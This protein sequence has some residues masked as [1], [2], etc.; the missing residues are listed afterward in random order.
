MHSPRVLLTSLVWFL[1]VGV[2]A[3]GDNPSKAPPSITLTPS[4]ITVKAGESVEVTASYLDSDGVST[5]ASD[6]TFTI[7]GT[8]IA[9]VTTGSGGHATVKGLA[10]GK[11]VLSV[12]GQDVTATFNV[13]VT[14]APVAT[15]SSIE[16]TP[17]NGMIALGTTQQMTATGVYSDASTKDL[18]AEAT[19]SSSAV[20]H[21]TIDA[22][23]IAH[24]VGVGATTITATV[25]TVSGSAQLTVTEAVLA[26]ITVAPADAE[27][28]AGHTQQYTATGHFSDATTQDLTAQ[29]TW[30]S[31]A[32][33]ATISNAAGSQG[34]ASGVS[35]GAATI[36]ATKGTVVG[37]TTLTVTAATLAAIEVT[38]PDTSNPIG[39]RRPLK[40]E[41]TFSDTST[42]TITAD[43]TWSSSDETIATVALTGPN[44]GEVT[45]VAKGTATI[46]AT[47]DGITGNT[48]FIVTDATLDTIEVTPANSST[49]LG[50][51]VQFKAE[52]K[53][54]DDSKVDLTTQVL[55]GSTN[56]TIAT[57]SNA[58]DKGNA[59]TLAV[60]T[61]TITAVF[62]SKSGT[63]DLTVTPVALDAVAVTPETAD[64][65]PGGKKQLA[66][67]EVFSDATSVDVSATAVWASSDTAIATVD[68]KGLVTGAAVGSADITATSGGL[69]GTMTIT[70]HG[71]SVTATLPRD[72]AFGIRTSTPIVITFDQ[73]IDLA[74]VT[75]QAAAGACT[76]NL[77]LSGDNFASCLGLGAPTLDTTGKIA[78][79]QP[80]AALAASAT[81]K[82]RVTNAVTNTAGGAGEAFAQATGFTTSAGGACATG[83][84]ISQVFGAGGNGGPNGSSFDSDFIEL[85]NGGATA[86]D[87][88]GFAVQYASVTGN[89]WQVSA[90]PTATLAAG[91]Y[92]LIKEGTGTNTAPA[93]PTPDFVPASPISMSGSQGKVALTAFTTPLTGTCPLGLTN[94]FV[95]YG[96]STSAGTCFEG[97][98]ATSALGNKIGAQRKTNGCTDANNNA[99]DFATDVPVPR[100]TATAPAVCACFAGAEGDDEAA[101]SF[102]SDDEASTM[103]QPGM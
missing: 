97:A 91:G 50:H 44:K 21:A 89:G 63:T 26:T 45:A 96:T 56:E 101:M 18:T 100:N 33:T 64:V 84:V 69:T 54:T 68:N 48:T 83:L 4:A 79:A 61:T 67:L 57:I 35:V 93:L 90:L 30:A 27:L 19:W 58:G 12:S 55:W 82:I 77:Q 31:S 75:V 34:L 10:E 14:A 73:A 46:T 62:G 29:V 88:T 8:T 28:A 51:H 38:P 52:G 1:L 36:T 5:A 60:G 78:T 92:F 74:S 6:A 102:L 98:G 15:L 16:V 72:T 11:T 7:A 49:A 94:D 32:A 3:C 80:T 71:P 65:I 47:L 53:F 66:A 86:I 23:G 70:V 81:F 59:T 43:V 76:G 42:R 25:G 40:A 99:A 95:G 39:I 17:T 37:M 24:S 103:A 9:S 2:V 20:D 41:G 85:H 13:T 87:L 22:T